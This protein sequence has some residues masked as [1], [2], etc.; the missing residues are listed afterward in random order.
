MAWREEMTWQQSE[1]QELW[2]GGQ[3]ELTANGTSLLRVFLA[4]PGLQAAGS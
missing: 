1:A 4:Q 3:Y 2:G